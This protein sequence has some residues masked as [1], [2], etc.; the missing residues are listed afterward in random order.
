[1]P[2]FP[3]RGWGRQWPPWVTCVGVCGD[4]LR[5]PPMRCA[6]TPQQSGGCY[7]AP[8]GAASL[9]PS[10]HCPGIPGWRG[11][12]GPGRGTPQC[13]G[14]GGGVSGA[15]EPQPLRFK[16]AGGISAAAK[17]NVTY[18]SACPR[19][20]RRSPRAG[21]GAR[22]SPTAPPARAGGP[23]TPTRPRARAGRRGFTGDTCKW[24][25]PGSAGR[26]WWVLGTRG[27]MQAG[28]E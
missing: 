15:A 7:R 8:M 19:T 26:C 24:G 10:L 5:D 17:T 9:T 2:R 3:R 13:G 27:D 12:R 14:A 11:A 23:R 16:S 18:F 22:R 6:L 28:G 20:E 4:P 21:H 25:P 1:M